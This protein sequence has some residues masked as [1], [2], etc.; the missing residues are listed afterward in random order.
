VARIAPR[1]YDEQVPETSGANKFRAVSRVLGRRAGESRW[2]RATYSAGRS[3]F[4]T[5]RY[6]VHVLFHQVTGFFFLLFG[7]VVGLAC[8]REYSAYAA[9]KLGPWRAILAGVLA[10]L[11]LYFA[12]S[13]FAR[14]GRKRK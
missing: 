2:S 5:V 11:F 1:I 8:Y 14:A 13:N 6:V 12:I 9:G 7:L 10:L 4:G 3:F